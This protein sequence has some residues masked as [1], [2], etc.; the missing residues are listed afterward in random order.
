M[1]NINFPLPLNAEITR[2]K[3]EKLIGAIGTMKLLKQGVWLYFILLIFEGALR[4]WFLPAL[5]SPLL[6][7]RDPI[8][9]GIIWLA[10]KRGLLVLNPNII[11]IWIV[12]AISILFSMIFGHKSAAVAFFGA[13]VFLFHFPLIYAIGRIFDRD[14]VIQ[15]GKITLWIAVPM[16]V[17]IATQFYSPQSAWVNRGVG[18][19]EEGAGFSGA[20]GYFR[21]PG[22]FSFTN[23]NGMFFGFVGAYVLYFWLNPGKVNKL[24]LVTATLAVL[25]SISLS[26]SR[27]LFFELL[28][29]LGFAMIAICFKPKYIGRMLI[30]VLGM[31]IAMA[32]LSQTEFFQTAT[33][34]FLHRFET[35]NEIEGGLEGVLGDRYMGGMLGAI[36]GVPVKIPLVGFGIG[37]GTNVGAMLLTGDVVF[38][39][40]EEEWGR[41][42]GEMGAPLGISI[43]F[44]RLKLCWQLTMACFSRLRMGD[45]LPW[46][47]LSFCLLCIPQGQWG[48]PTALGFGTLIAG[49][50]IAS[51]RVPRTKKQNFSIQTKS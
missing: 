28:V 19:S 18:G 51:L 40:S 50:V 6:I 13:R 49:L 42:I 4:K 48:Q 5:S 36:A 38:L 33:E 32:L 29:S 34:A 22:T 7:V 21:P 35:A 44:I 25:A 41:L 8:A 23:G 9:L 31:V 27:T 47:L 1:Q 14:D 17:L 43:I 30:A 45:L 2:R 26:I 3:K 16:V 12:T 46:M 37:M 10:W 11:A 24:L 20:L 15:L 39:I